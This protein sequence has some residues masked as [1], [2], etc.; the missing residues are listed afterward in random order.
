MPT[1]Y[2]TGSHL[3][4]HQFHAPPTEKVCHF[5]IHSVVYVDEPV[6]AVP[7]WGELARMQPGQTAV[8][9]FAG[10]MGFFP[11]QTH[12]AAVHTSPIS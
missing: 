4:L 7:R 11:E 5:S 2:M 8:E 9:A 10:R 1:P 12:R 3:S 6:R